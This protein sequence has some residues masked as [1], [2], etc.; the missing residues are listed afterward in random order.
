[1]RSSVPD[2]D[3]ATI[4]EEA[5]TEKL[6]KLE[7]K[8]YGKTKAPRKNLEEADTSPFSRYISAPVRRAVYERDGGQC[9]YR[10]QTGRR[11]T[12]TQQLEFHHLKPY[13]RGGDRSPANICLL[14]R[15]HNAYIAEHDYGKEF[16]EQFRK[17]SSG[18]AEPAVVYTSTESFTPPSPPPP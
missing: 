6:E 3:L 16:M 1:M 13:G 11:C 8:R 9:V 17:S 2:G 18:V 14:C 15:A 5:V 4:L 10:D 12:E 7:A